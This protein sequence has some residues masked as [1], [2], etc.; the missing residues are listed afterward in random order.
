MSH[1]KIC[2]KYQ[3][4][5]KNRLTWIKMRIIRLISQNLT[6]NVQRRNFHQNLEGGQK[7]KSIIGLKEATELQH[8]A[9]NEQ[10][11]RVDEQDRNLGQISKRECHRVNNG[12]IPLHR[13]FSVFLFNSRGQMLLQQRSSYKITYPN[14]YTNACCSHPLHEIEGEREEVNALGIRRAAQRRLN[15]ELG[16]PM[17]QIRPE[18][19]HYLTRI[20]YKDLGDGVWGEHEIDYILFLQKDV[21]LNPNANE[22]SDIRFISRE[23]YKKEIEALPGELTP[24]FKLI[25]KHRLP[26]WWNDLSKLKLHE[27]LDTIYK[28]S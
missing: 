12:H 20:H 13:A 24:W 21:D 17:H 23:N 1:H 28:F 11:I 6:K 8:T 26:V 27:D 10:C 19:M 7:V 18:N 3:F 15:H 9:M 4:D 14:H 2:Q 5:T 25:L 16:I 22:I